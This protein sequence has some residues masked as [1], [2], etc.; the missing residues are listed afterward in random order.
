MD[1]HTFSFRHPS[2]RHFLSL[3]NQ[4]AMSIL[5]SAHPPYYFNTNCVSLWVL[6]PGRCCFFATKA[7]I[8]RTLSLCHRQM[9]H[10]GLFRSRGPVWVMWDYVGPV[11]LCGS[12][13]LVWVMCDY[14]GPVGL[15]GSR[16]P[17]WITWACV[18]HVG[19]RQLSG[20]E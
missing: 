8:T 14:V 7:L 19:D 12:R 5:F 6:G 13:G 15:C 9:G 18:V 4:L 17:V 16:G 20:K 2:V 1:F 11:G 3:L 10:V